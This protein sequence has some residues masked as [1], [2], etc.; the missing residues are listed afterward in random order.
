MQIKLNEDYSE[1]RKEN[2]LNIDS[3]SKEINEFNCFFENPLEISFDSSK[4]HLKRQTEANF[5]D[6]FLKPEKD[7]QNCVTEATEESAISQR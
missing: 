6:L 2:S 1:E 3:E 7:Y 4:S 5:E